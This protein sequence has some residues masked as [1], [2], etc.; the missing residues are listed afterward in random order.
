VKRLGHDGFPSDETLLA[1]CEERLDPETRQRVN[2]HMNACTDC[3]SALIVPREVKRRYQGAEASPTRRVTAG[4][5]SGWKRLVALTV[6]TTSIG[7]GALLYLRWSQSE[8]HRIAV[9]ASVAPSKRSFEGRISNFPYRPFVASAMSVEAAAS[10]WAGSRNFAFVGGMTSSTAADFHVLGISHLVAGKSAKAVRA[11]ERSLLLTTG[12][13][14]IQSA[15]AVTTDV[16]LLTDLSTAY[17][18]RGTSSGTASDYIRALNCADRAWRIGHTAE[19]SWNRTV[20]LQ[21]L[22]LIDDA[23]EGWLAYVQNEPASPWSTEARKRLKDTEGAPE[24]TQWLREGGRLLNLSADRAE[25]LSLQFPLQVRRAAEKEILPAWATA[26]LSGNVANAAVCVER[27]HEIGATFARRSGESFLQDVSSNIDLWANDRAA[28]RRLARA[29]IAVAEAKAAYDHGNGKTCRAKLQVAIPELLRYKSPLIYYARFYI[30]ASYYH[31]ND[32]ASLRSEAATLTDIPSRYLALHAQ[33][34]WILGLGELSTG[35]PDGALPHYEAAL[36]TFA[37]LGESDY[38]AAAHILLA[39]AYDYLDSSDEAWAHRERALELISRMGPSSS[40]WV[41]LLRGSAELLLATRQPSVAMILLDRAL[42]LPATAADPLF[43]AETIS[44]QAVALHQLGRGAEANAAWKRAFGVATS[45]RIAAV[46]DRALND[47]TLTRALTLERGITSDEMQR[48]VAFAQSSSNRWALPRLL[49]L[50]AD[51][52][53]RQGSYQEA[54]RGYVEAVDEIVGQRHKT[55]LARYELLN[56]SCLSDVTEHALALALSRADY[57]T[58]FRFSE[59]SAGAAFRDMPFAAKPQ[60]PPNVAIVKI[61]CLSDRMLI[62]TITAR[63]VHDRQVRVA[64]ETVQKAVE[65]ID[66]GGHPE[67]AASLGSMII[68]PAVIGPAVDTLIFV[69]DA[70]VATLPFEALTDPATR[71]SLIERYVVAQCPTVGSYLRAVAAND[72]PTVAAL[73]LVDGSNPGNLPRLPQAVQ[74]IRGLRQRYPSATVWNADT[75]A[76]ATLPEALRNAGMIHVA[77]HGV[78]DRTNER[79]SNL[80]LGAQNKLLY[81][82]EVEALR[83][84]RHPIVVLSTCSGAATARL[85]RRRAPTFADAFLAAGASAVVASAEPIDDERARRF[86]VLLHERLRRGMAVGRAVREIQLIFAREG[87]QWSDL[88][89]IGNPAATFR[90]AP[91]ISTSSERRG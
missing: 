57:E 16:N 28:Q 38:V 17:L 11:L 74:E 39:E 75:N 13:R 48:A 42:K 8:F 64:I 46:R 71:K 23:R 50:Q 22:H 14:D 35:K 44:W 45:I 68:S 87:L 66:G 65:D 9:L 79:L 56:R 86:S 31:D 77:A 47:V 90:P 54:M 30:A 78:V 32:F 85:R 81:A 67:T 91:E 53:A 24:S 63:G 3:Y 73:L 84:S 5:Q 10:S 82:H 61:V 27:L 2:E 25:R 6:S 59:H 80:V 55:S 76:M 43:L 12:V 37:R 83:L 18:S 20:S 21:R 70:S 7:C 88:V 69:P 60:A 4:R 19:A 52:R 62:R 33:T 29:I 40:Q 89:I 26:V 34:S 51:V 58:A 72:T 1:F 15:A 36:T 41:Q 49:R